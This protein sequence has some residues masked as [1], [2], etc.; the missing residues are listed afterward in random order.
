MGLGE[1]SPDSRRRCAEGNHCLDGSGLITQ[2]L[3]MALSR[4]YKLSLHHI[5]NN[6]LIPC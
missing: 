5:D 3:N 6:P 4:Q 1:G 2:A